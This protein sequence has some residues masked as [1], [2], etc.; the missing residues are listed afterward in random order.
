MGQAEA[1]GLQ[2]GM[3]GRRG[4][5]AEAGVSPEGVSPVGRAGAGRAP[6]DGVAATGP[7]GVGGGVAS[8]GNGMEL[9]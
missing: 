2:D 4:G 7:D 1:G 5:Q 3:R 9:S 8:L 6:G